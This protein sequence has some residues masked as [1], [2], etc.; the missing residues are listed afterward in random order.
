MHVLLYRICTCHLYFPEILWNLVTSYYL[1][2]SRRSCSS[3]SSA[4]RAPTDLELVLS[5]AE[6][7]EPLWAQLSCDLELRLQT[8][9]Y[10]IN[11]QVGLLGSWDY[12]ETLHVCTHTHTH[13]RMLPYTLFH[14]CN[15]LC[16]ASSIKPL[17]SVC[18]HFT[19][20]PKYSKSC[21]PPCLFWALWH[22]APAA[23]CTVQHCSTAAL[24]HCRVQEWCDGGQVTMH[25]AAH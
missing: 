1:H 24:Q 15:I 8:D 2:L 5:S 13:S 4:T 10:L 23:A 3:L 16:H 20:T 9:L 18:N 17:P 19:P 7:A 14:P 25:A 12:T 21:F 22:P 11:S 6:E